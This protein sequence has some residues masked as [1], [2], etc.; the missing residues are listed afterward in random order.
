MDGLPPT[1]TV[2]GASWSSTWLGGIATAA[3]RTRYTAHTFHHDQ[4]LQATSPFM[5]G[6]GA[7]KSAKMKGKKI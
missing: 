6:P 5:D 1:I 2:I 4:K 3:I 7:Y